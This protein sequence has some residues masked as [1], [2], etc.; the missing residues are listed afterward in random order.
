MS[1]VLYFASV[2]LLFGPLW[3]QFGKKKT[4]PKT[5]LSQ[6]NDHKDL[7]SLKLLKDDSSTGFPS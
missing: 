5:M 2:W 7:S 3:L 6:K 4:K 1:E